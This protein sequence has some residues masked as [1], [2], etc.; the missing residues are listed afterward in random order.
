MALRG[1]RLVVALAMAIATVVA[2]SN[3][4]DGTLTVGTSADGLSE[5][6]SSTTNGSP[7]TGA[8]C[9]SFDVDEARLTDPGPLVAGYK[10]LGD[11]FDSGG[12]ATLQLI[13]TDGDGN[14]LPTSFTAEGGRVL[15]VRHLPTGDERQ[16]C[17]KLD[18]DDDGTLNPADCRPT[19]DEKSGSVATAADEALIQSFLRFATEPTPA[20]A[21]EM[22]FADDVALGLGNE[23]HTNV[24]RTQI[25]DATR[26]SIDV[27]YFRAHEGPFSALDLAADSGEVLVSIGEHPHC[28]SPPM[29]PPEEVAELRRVSVRPAPES[30]DSCL[31]WWTVDLFVTSEGK[32]AAVTLDIWEP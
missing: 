2:C 31:Q 5:P 11:A 18:G 7:P 4:A 1:T 17:S 25:A 32:V 20:T 23:I 28:A 26:W 12:T 9:G 14:R 21:E 24:T 22:P 10:C 16:V 8:S 19:T 29:P 27:D 15:V 13:F 3:D 30:I 6:S